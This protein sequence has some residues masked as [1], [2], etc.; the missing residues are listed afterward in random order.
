MQQML[1]NFFALC[2]LI[3]LLTQCD[4]EQKSFVET[5][6]EILILAEDGD[7][8]EIPEGEYVFARPI[9]LQDVDK[10]TIRGAGM[11]KSV[12][13]FKDQL[14]GGEGML[15]KNCNDLTLE[16]FSVKDSQGDAIK[17]QGCEGVIMR[18]L[19]TTWSAGKSS[20]NGG[21][22][23][24][25][26]TC[27]KVLMEYCEASY[28][29]DAGIYVGQSTDVIVRNNY[30][31]NNVAGIEI[32]NTIR[33]DVY[34]NRM[35]HNTGGL[36]VFDMPDLPQANGSHIHIHDNIMEDNNGENFSAPGIVVNILPPGSGLVMMAHHTIEA[37]NNV[38]KDHNTIS[39]AILSWQF[40]GRPFQS[41]LYDPFF[42][43]LTIYNNEIQS[44]DGNADTSTD[45][46]KIIASVTQGKGADI[47]MDGILNPA[48]FNES[49]QLQKD[50]TICIQNNGDIDFMNL[51]AAEA[52]NPDGELDPA[53]LA[54][55]VSNDITLFSCDRKGIVNLHTWL[56]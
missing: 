24:Y 27:S 20:K 50:H 44:A 41:E 55:S 4:Q 11:K 10:V 22:G 29:M 26:V 47:M 43:N 32:E 35:E 19:E 42:H 14:E 56:D 6:Q 34:N 1:K 9:S 38:I 36:L 15:I 23:L 31:H 16:G 52:I 51:N 5:F 46:G 39:L 13:S 17:V 28:A 7:V 21:Y 45:F 30:A 54:T 8:I 2:L 37:N 3:G 33:A 48:F 18:K 40:T 53:K 25:P 49:G 12:L